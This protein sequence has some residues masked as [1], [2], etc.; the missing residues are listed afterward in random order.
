M[1]SL[2]KVLTSTQTTG[3]EFYG[4]GKIAAIMLFDYVTGST[5]K[6]QFRNPEK[7]TDWVDDEAEF[8]DEGIKAF[9]NFRHIKY[10]VVSTAA[11][12]TAWVVSND[13]QDGFTKA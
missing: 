13:F 4:T 6:L 10:R 3:L 7:P 9:H 1:A 5:I 11:G 8:A 12:A 2:L